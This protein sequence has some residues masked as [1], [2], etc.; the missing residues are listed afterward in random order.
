MREVQIDWT[1]VRRLRAEGLVWREVAERLDVNRNTLRRKAGRK[2]RALDAGA[3]HDATGGAAHEPPVAEARGHPAPVFAASPC[4]EPPLAELFS[5]ARR[6][7]AV[8]DA[9]DP[10]ITHETIRIPTDRPVALIFTSC[11]HLGSRYTFYEGFE[12]IFSRVLGL[13]R[14]YWLSLGDDVEGFLPGFPDGSAIVDQAVA[15]PRAQRRMLAGVLDKLAVQGKL[16]CGCASQHG[17]DW[18][19]KR[20][21]DDPIK[22]LYLERHVPFFDGKGLIQLQVGTE[23]YNLAVAHEFPGS[24]QYNKNHSQRRAALFDFPGADVVV[25]GDKHS[26]AVQE[27]SLPPFEFDA[28]LRATYTQ[29]L[30][31]V[32]TAKTGNDKYSI[33]GWSRGVLEWPVLIFRPDRHFIAHARDLSLVELMLDAW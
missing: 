3:G 5:L 18:V 6:S 28:G 17:G 14:C 11:A 25:Q 10:V 33:R 22:D 29:W 30:V 7:Q 13:D 31:Q 24:S 27:F 15:N 1:E 26:Y 21:G 9:L 4:A 8:L 2:L 23:T 19:R 32:G 16:L 12:A 20:T